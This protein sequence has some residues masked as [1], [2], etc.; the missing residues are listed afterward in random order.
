L[1]EA[2]ATEESVCSSNEAYTRSLSS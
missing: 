1:D 2:Q